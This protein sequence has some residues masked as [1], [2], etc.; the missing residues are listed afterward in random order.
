MADQW[1]I[2]QCIEATGG[3]QRCTR[4][5][6]APIIR[7]WET[8]YFLIDCLDLWCGAS[9]VGKS[10]RPRNKWPLQKGLPHFHFHHSFNLFRVWG[11]VEHCYPFRCPTKQNINGF[12][13]LMPCL[14]VSHECTSSQIKCLQ[15]SPLPEECE[16]FSFFLAGKIVDWESLHLLIA[17]VGIS[18]PI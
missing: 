12:Y 17:C 8:L 14:C 1:I 11:C 18:M 13:A 6:M 3:S 2:I 10:C 16:D 9:C 15:T 5:I 7:H 4:P